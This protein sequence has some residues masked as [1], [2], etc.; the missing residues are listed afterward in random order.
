MLNS[1]ILLPAAYL[2]SIS[3]FCALVKGNCVVDLGEHFI[4]R[5]ERNRARIMTSDG[6]MELTAQV[7]RANRPRQPMSSMR[8]DYSKRWQKQHWGA[9]VAAYKASPYFDYYAP[10]L[11]RFYQHEYESLS[12][13]NLALISELCA[14]L[15]LSV[16]EVSYSYLTATPDDL[17]LRPKTKSPTFLV[18]PYIQVFADRQPYVA[19]LSIVDLLFNEGPAASAVLKRCQPEW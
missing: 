3:W 19:D 15:G 5:S 9:L 10:R 14:M 1:R 8:L 7:V 11:E 17:D 12:E 18:E 2:P 4:K 16:P 13:F 6:V